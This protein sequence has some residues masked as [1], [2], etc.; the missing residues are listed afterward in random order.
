MTPE[1]T[2]VMPAAMKAYW[3]PTARPAA[4]VNIAATALNF[5]TPNAPPICELAFA[6]PEASPVE[7]DGM[8]EAITLVDGVKRRQ[9]VR[10]RHPRRLIRG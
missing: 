9:C 7:V 3:T 6:S 10:H 5:A 1:A 2:A 4:R 8:P